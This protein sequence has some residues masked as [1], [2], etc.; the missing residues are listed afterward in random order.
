MAEKILTVKHGDSDTFTDV[1]SNLDSLSGYTAKMYVYDPDGDL[2]L[3]ITGSINT[4]TVTYE[5]TNDVCKALSVAKYYYESK[6][7]DGS[8]HVYTP[9]WGPFII[10]AAKNSDPS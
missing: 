4:L 6:V 10:T 1:V 2:A 8:D 7:F 3:T 5:L 9:S